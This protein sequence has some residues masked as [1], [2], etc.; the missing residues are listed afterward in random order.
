ML[1]GWDIQKKKKDN[2]IK[3]TG[4]KEKYEKIIVD[5][6]SLDDVIKKIKECINKSNGELRS[7]EIII[8]Y[9]GGTKTMSAGAVFVGLLEKDVKVSLTKG[10][11][12][13]IFK[14]SGE[15]ITELIDTEYIKIE[16]MKNL[17]NEMISH[18]LYTS[19]KMLLKRFL[20]NQ[21]ISDKSKREIEERIK[22]VSIFEY[23]DKFNHNE[24]YQIFRK[25]NSIRERY[26]EHFNYILK[27]LGRIKNSG[28]ELLFD[29]IKNSERKAYNNNYDDAVARIYRSIELFL[30]I[31]CKDLKL[32]VPKIG[33][34]GLYESL[35]EKDEK[36][37]DTLEE[38][39][40]KIKHKISLRNESILA[41]GIKSISENEY[42][43]IKSI[44]D[45]FINKCFEKINV[46][47]EYPPEFPKQ[48]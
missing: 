26:N 10:D 38:Y 15:P 40:G 7:D 22:V 8:D 46:R 11:R 36:L 47:I 13:D 21:T 20:A 42:L 25:Y 9:T 29:L 43:D 39:K 45:E 16:N 4:Y 37:K 34:E 19:A 17:V 5:P 2:L 6:D 33:L 12:S 28:Y 14:A 30:Q 24:A 35:M 44:F 23:W 32:N 48:I 3:L 18:Y 27:I 41:H 31:R 1:M